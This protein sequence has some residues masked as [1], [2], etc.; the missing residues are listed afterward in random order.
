MAKGGWQ[1]IAHHDNESAVVTV[2]MP[3]GTMAPI[4]HLVVDNSQKTLGV[5]MCLS[6]NSTGSLCQMKEK[7]QKWLDSLTAGH[8]HCQMMSGLPSSTDCAIAWPHCQS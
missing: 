7:A 8:L 1:Y 6:G 3:D 4:T 2:P 5:V